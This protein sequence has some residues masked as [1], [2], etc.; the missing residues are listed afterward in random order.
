MHIVEAKLKRAEEAYARKSSGENALALFAR[1]VFAGKT[2]EKDGLYLSKA[3]HVAVTAHK[4]DLLDL[5]F[6]SAH[7]YA[8]VL[9]E[10]YESAFEIIRQ[11]EEHSSFLSKNSPLFYGQVLYF[12][13][14]IQTK[15][16]KSRSAKKIQRNIEILYEKTELTPLLAYLGG[17][18]RHVYGDVQ[19]C[20]K[21]YCE[22]MEKG[23]NGVF[24]FL[25]TYEMLLEQETYNEDMNELAIV[26]IP[27]ALS[28]DLPVDKLLE[29]LEKRTLIGVLFS[30]NSSHLSRIYELYGH[31]S[32]F[33][34]LCQKLIFEGDTSARALSYY[35]LALEQRINLRGLEKISVIA[36]YV[37]KYYDLPLFVIEAALQKQA[38]Y[39][40]DEL[41]FLFGILA[42]RYENTEAFGE[43]REEIVKFGAW[44]L[45][46]DVRGR[47]Y[48]LIY[49][50]LFDMLPEDARLSK[51]M[52]EEI[53]AYEIEFDGQIP[54]Y[55]C[56]S[57]NAKKGLYAYPVLDGKCVIK[58]IC[59][60]K[61]YFI[62][63]NANEYLSIGDYKIT[64][65]LE[66]VTVDLCESLY[67]RGF[68]D[69]DIIMSLAK[70][71]T[72]E[73]GLKK[74]SIEFLQRAALTD[75][76]SDS[77]KNEI[78]LKLAN[79]YASLEQYSLAVHYYG[80]VCDSATDSESA[81]GELKTYIATGRCEEAVSVIERKRS[82]LPDDIVFDSLRTLHEYAG[83][84]ETALL[85]YDLILN[86]MCAP[87]ILNI[88]F[89]QFRGT[90]DEWLTIANKID[91]LGFDVTQLYEKIIINGI[92]TGSIGSDC[93]EAFARLYGADRNNPVI[94]KYAYFC[95]YEI[96][97]N[98]KSLPDGIADILEG[99]YR[100]DDSDEILCYALSLN[101]VREER[102]D[103][104]P[105][106]S[107]AAARMEESGMILPEVKRYQDKN[108]ISS[109]IEKNTPFFY[110]KTAH[111][112][113][114][115]RYRT[116][117]QTAY[118]KKKMN[119][120]KFGIYT[121]NIPLFYGETITYYFEEEN[122]AKT[123]PETY[124][125]TQMR[126]IEQFKDPFYKVNNMVIYERMMKFDV[127]ET[128]IEAE[129][130]SDDDFP[131]ITI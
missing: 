7:L 105:L 65:T 79:H 92:F 130:N 72:A 117:G 23:L 83:S 37:N 100:E 80:L 10:N 69:T 94:A 106:I 35:A 74:S 52:Y 12:Y 95:C 9:L 107:E 8:N 103:K 119:Y 116:D 26:I 129:L 109:Y 5:R 81:Q 34:L 96:V 71:Y 45:S 50:H 102:H 11:L 27:W 64:K 42:S 62:G 131:V 126:V 59:D 121:V 32:A 43:L 36:A 24:F 39:K 30:L 111:K 110:I 75:V 13:S 90:P 98:G 29:R 21:M 53:F 58:S 122:G 93:N 120:F 112:N 18:Q 68:R 41:A 54:Q 17:I 97:R 128:L 87:E 6:I 89:K 77:L 127:V 123:E 99:I 60:F 67:G 73:D 2:I 91:S 57:D 3:Y 70:A 28:R 63:E 49:R 125:K 16:D 82:A 44:A 124:T 86:D 19:L 15:L 31:A 113:V 33:Q 85:S 40:V 51:I 38:D 84:L 66:N 88:V 25:D 55:V 78:N 101:Y 108:F 20:A 4:D 14:I 104:L 76:I 115:F 1:Y 48:N 47:D 118:A 61:C 22:A 46:N 114:F 56:V